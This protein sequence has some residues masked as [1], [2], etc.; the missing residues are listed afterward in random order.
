M[1]PRSTLFRQ[2]A[3]LVALIL[4]VA[5]MAPSTA[6][7]WVA[8]A[9]L[10]SLLLFAVVSLSRHR[11]IQKLT[12]QI[13]E[14]LH[15]GRSVQFEKCREGD[16][17]VLANELEKMV[18]RLARATELLQKER[19]GLADSLADVS[20]QIRTPLTAAE[21]MLAAVERE[22]DPRERK[23][24]LRQLENQMERISW[25]VT[26]L[27]KIA[28]VDAGAIRVQQA[29]VNAASCVARAASPLE[30][31]LDLR[32]VALVLDIPT[33]AHFTGD[34]LWTAEALENILKNCMEK[35][36]AGGTITVAARETSLATTLR[37]FDTGP[38]IA[39]EDLPHIFDRFYR[40]SNAAE[41]GVAKPL[42]NASPCCREGHIADEAALSTGCDPQSGGMAVAQCE[43]RLSAAAPEGFGIGLS[44]AQAL[45]SA[46]GGTLQ[47]A[48][49][50]QGGAEFTITFPKLVV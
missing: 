22:E 31:A 26:T 36:P 42:R 14:V 8:A 21:L 15:N 2:C 20:H 17:A 12:A 19:S 49:L 16:I 43:P 25:L 7:V 6:R 33:T 13:D 41:E 29:P 45:V 24:L 10:V 27:L 23:R 46:Q 30:T 35:T 11:Q 48:N 37:I 34:E 18:S 40:G 5:A 4:L 47:A 9:G 38:G 32:D 39:P 1:G 50:P 3:L 28:K 44:L